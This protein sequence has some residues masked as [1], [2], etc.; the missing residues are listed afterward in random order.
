MGDMSAEGCWVCTVLR[1]DRIH[2]HIAFKEPD[3][4]SRLWKSKSEYLGQQGVYWGRLLVMALPGDY[5]NI[6]GTPIV[7]SL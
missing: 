7:G 4:K 6:R 5:G 3:A 1:L 2:W